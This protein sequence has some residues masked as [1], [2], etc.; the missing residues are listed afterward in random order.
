MWIRCLVP[1]VMVL[2]FQ[3]QDDDAKKKE[4]KA[5]EGNWVMHALEIDG[6]EVGLDQLKDT[7]L[8]VKGSDY[9]VKIKEQSLECSI[10]LDPS[11]S[12]KHI[13]MTFREKGSADKVHKGIYELKE[14]T[15]KISRGVTPQHERPT[16]FATWPN[17]GYFVVTWKKK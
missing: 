13:D 3:G 9:V 8:T 15:L 12:P 17:T 7:T 5:L 6:K 16:L 1:F 2:A 4:L 10:Q 14:D 11:K